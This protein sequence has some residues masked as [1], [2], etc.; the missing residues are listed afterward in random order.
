VDTRVAVTC[1]THVFIIQS[2]LKRLYAS[3]VCE[4][5]EQDA[6]FFL[7]IYSNLIIVYMYR[8]NKFII[9]RLILYLQ[10]TAFHM[11]KLY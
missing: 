10:H 9:R 5:D 1:R 6:H 7:L 4:K 2:T 3:V 11:L 8:T